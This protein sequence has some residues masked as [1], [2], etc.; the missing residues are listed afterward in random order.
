MRLLMGKDLL[1]RSKLFKHHENLRYMV[2]AKTWMSL[3][4]VVIMVLSVIGFVLVDL[5]SSDTKRSFGEYTFYRTSQGWRAKIAGQ[6]LYF[7]FVPD[8]ISTIQVDER[9]SQILTASPILAITY[10]A[11]NTYAQSMGQLQYYVEQLLNQNQKVYVV[12]G[13]VNN[14]AFQS[15]PQITCANSSQSL[16]VIVFEKS[17]TTQIISTDW[18][19][20]AEAATGQDFF[21]LADRILY[22]ILGVL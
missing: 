6:N 18:C 7:N 1:L 16:P 15:L 11:N 22:E 14:T 17:N 9:S 13:L 5:G 4:I 10:D 12:R 21:M 20:H 3:F 2:E 19:I 8:Q